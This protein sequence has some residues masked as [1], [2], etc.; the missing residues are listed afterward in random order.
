M[1]RYKVQWAYAKKIGTPSIHTNEAGA[2]GEV[3]HLLGTWIRR[4][5]SD[6]LNRL[7][8]DPQKHRDLREGLEFLVPELQRLIAGDQVWE[9]YEL[10]ED[11]YIR[12]E[13][14]FDEYP[15]FVAIGTVIVEGSDSTGLKN[16][17]PL[18]ETTDVA[19]IDLVKTPLTVINRLDEAKERLL[20]D[21]VEVIGRKASLKNIEITE[22]DF[23]NA[24]MATE[25]EI[26][27]KFSLM[28]EEAE[29]QYLSMF[30]E[31]ILRR[32]FPKSSGIGLGVFKRW[33]VQYCY[34]DSCHPSIH[35][36]EERAKEDTRVRLTTLL[37]HL[38]MHA[39][40]PTVV[41]RESGYADDIER[42][43]PHIEFLLDN[44]YV[45]AAYF[46][47]KAFEKKWDYHFAAFPLWM[48]VGSMRVIPEPEP[49]PTPW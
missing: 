16:R 21:L 31:G 2:R 37:R 11:F 49:E 15:L 8:K 39:D 6:Y 24:L 28:D 3:V 33:V 18:L 41:D 42:L 1:K 9:A 4:N 38:S 20:R 30:R 36:S 19:P 5:L 45:W 17:I 35:T 22:S 23:F 44:N 25:R 43:I 13:K 10:W 29:S 48:S 47:Y 46:D 32:L 27:G 7:R 12:F 26:V 40:S 14:E 34:G